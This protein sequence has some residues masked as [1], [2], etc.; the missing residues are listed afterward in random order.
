M[1]LDSKHCWNYFSSVVFVMALEIQIGRT[2]ALTPV[3]KIDPITIGGVVVSNATLH[4]EDEI[5]RKDIKIGDAVCVQRAGDVI[6]QV[7]YVD[8]SKRDKNTKQFIFPQKCPSCGSR[9]VKEFNDIAWAKPD[10]LTDVAK[11]GIETPQDLMNAK[12]LDAILFGG[13]F[14]CK[15]FDI[16]L[17]DIFKKVFCKNFFECQ[18]NVHN[19]S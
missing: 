12:E 6:P 1:G 2:G 19:L 8:K 3:A 10:D 4:N 16:P 14:V 15:N 13:N 7:L 9:V 11:Y 17:K 18:K 5:N